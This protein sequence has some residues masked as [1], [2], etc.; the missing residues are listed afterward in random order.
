M[1]GNVPERRSA[2][3]R[4]VPPDE[5][6]VM[7]GAGLAGGLAVARRRTPKPTDRLRNPL[8]W[9][10]TAAVVL[11]LLLAITLASD[12]GSPSGGSKSTAPTTFY[13]NLGPAISSAKGSYWSWPASGQPGLV[14]AEGLASPAALGP[15]VN[16]SHLGTVACAPTIISSALGPLPADSGNVSAG[17][18]PVWLYAFLATGN[19]LVVVATSSGSASVVATTPVQ[20]DCYRGPGSFSTV[21]VDSSIAAQAAAATR[22]AGQFLAAASANMSAVSVELFLAP[23]GFLAHGPMGDPVWILTD[24]TCPLYGGS[25]SSSGSELTTVVDATSGMLYSQN[26]TTTIC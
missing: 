21:P 15:A 13:G 12:V 9:A 17:A 6:P 3:G 1:H 11:A 19:T 5:V 16:V 8:L 25:S 20:G 18:A 26:T 23:P 22:L 24:S 14:F 2:G 7:D 4:G 10:V